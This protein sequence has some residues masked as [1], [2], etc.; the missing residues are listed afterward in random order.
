MRPPLKVNIFLVFLLLVSCAKTEKKSGYDGF[1]ADSIDEKTLKEF[2]P[3][4]INPQLTMAIQT[5]LDIRSPGAGIISN[6]GKNLYASWSVTGTT[7]TW[8]IPGPKQFPTQL[9]SGEDATYITGIT[10][11]GKTLFLSRDSG[12]DEMPGL[13]M[14]NAKGGPLVEIYRKRKT[15]VFLSYIYNNDEILIRAN[16]TNP[17]SYNLYRY[18][19]KTKKKTMVF[20]GEPEGYWVMHDYRASDQTYLLGRWFGNTHSE[21]YFYNEKNKKL[22]PALGTEEQEYYDAYFSAKNNELIVK[23]NKFGEFQSLYRY[24]INLNKFIPL[25]DNLK[26]DISSV[27]IDKKKTKLVYSYNNGGYYKIGALSLKNYRKLP[28]QNIKNK[29]VLQTYFASM[30]EN[31]RYMSL[32]A[33]LTDSPGT[34]YVYDWKTG[35]MRE[36]TRPSIPEVDVSNLPVPKLEY[37]TARDGTKIPMFV[38]RPTQCRKKVCHVVVDFHGGPEAQSIPWFR[39]L[40]KMLF[41]RDIIYVEP[42]VR[43]SRGYGKTWMN[44]DNGP[45]R[46]EVL[47]DIKDVALYIKKNWAKGGETPKVVAMGG[48]Y[49]GYSAFAA[50]TIYAGT[51]ELGIPIVGMSDLVSFL[52]NTAPYRRKLRE[53]EYGFL[54]KDME[55]LKKLSPIN[56][57]D[58]LQDPLLIIHGANDPRV[59]AGE[60]IQIMRKMQEKNLPGQLLLFPD[61]GHGVRKRKNRAVYW[62][63]ILDF[64]DKNLK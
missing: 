59:P 30:S 35:R 21:L 16:D 13:Y 50:M 45:K 40:N 22:V 26:G 12:G 60:A 61:E 55:A 14:Q 62:T 18:N 39:P 29:K 41:E 27:K 17:K 37:Y 64:L 25:L 51:F 19:L 9:T 5:M 38:T 52:Q 1:G 7:Q 57:L 36:W 63:Y 46:L 49:G 58:R 47:T 8:H 56:Y 42:N 54:D 10:P 53:S 43:G 2:A 34:T 32:K 6:D 23:T 28:F 31:G 44:A 24:Q 20:N 4:N 15:Q 11:D 33:V 3:Q 48:S